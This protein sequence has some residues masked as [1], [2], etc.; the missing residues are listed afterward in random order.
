MRILHTS[1]WHMGDSLGRVDR[2][3]DII[4]SLE[5]IAGYLDQRKADVML[6]TGDLFSDRLRP[7][8]LRAA[9]SEIRRIFLPF[10]ERG[11]TILAISGNHDSEVF[12]E[13]LRD[14][15]DLAAPAKR[16]SANAT[17]RLYIAPN[18]RRITLP[19]GDGCVQFVLMPYPTP[20]C[21]LRGER[22]WKAIEEKHRAMQE[23]F[24]GTLNRLR[25]ELDP[26]YPSVLMSHVHVR[27][28]GVGHK[29]FRIS[30]VEDVIFEPGDIPAEFAYIAYGHIHR[31]QEAVK[32]ASHIRYAGSIERLDIAESEDEKSVVL[33]EVGKA[34]RVSEPEILPL[35]CAP[36]YRVEIND[37]DAELPGLAE[38]YK[39]WQPDRALVQCSVRWRPDRHNLDEIYKTIETVFPRCYALDPIEIGADDSPISDFSPQRIERVVETVREYLQMRLEGNEQRDELIAL[40]ESLMAEEG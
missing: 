12:F 33:I 30:E 21:Y 38:R 40:A 31:P 25:S 1:D 10:L 18:P 34:G 15:L 22:G 16:G 13:T 6:A 32:G 5:Q 4:R 7:E 26:R 37:P 17:A 19:D 2:S 8:Q 28:V 11:G 9:V 35:D 24:V 20:R 14:A 3:G 29:L 36:I 39:D 23:R 27:G